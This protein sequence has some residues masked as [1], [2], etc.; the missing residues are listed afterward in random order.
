MLKQRHFIIK[1]F[2]EFSANARQEKKF[3]G[4]TI[5]VSDALDLFSD[6]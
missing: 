4:M 3:L 2:D 5:K 6:I 1:A